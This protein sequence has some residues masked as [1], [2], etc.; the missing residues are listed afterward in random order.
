MEKPPP[1]PGHGRWCNN[2]KRQGPG[3]CRKPA[4]WG[5]NH[6]GIGACR[7]HL[8]NVRN[9]RTAAANE[10][11]QRQL[12]RLDLPPVN[13]PLTALAD[14]AGQV[15]GF[16]DVVADRV[17]AL[18]AIRFTDDKGAEQLR[19]EV[20]LFERAL[21]RCEKFLTSMA[22]LNIDERLAAIEQQKVDMV[23]AAL[24]AAL[25]ELGL[26]EDQQR[27]ASDGISRRLRVVAG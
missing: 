5:T 11:A 27:E 18:S 7:L 9:H 25:A 10:Q 14:I 8:G 12:A 15:V 24:S 17:N 2:P 20:A 26:T 21:D 3:L 6:P 22:R 16:K 23:T 19:S 13:D 4:G 1:P